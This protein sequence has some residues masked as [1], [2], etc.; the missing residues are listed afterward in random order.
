MQKTWLSVALDKEQI[1]WIKARAC[2]P[3]KRGPGVSSALRAALDEA[4]RRDE[5]AERL[6]KLCQ[7]T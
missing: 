3:D 5:L 4:K 1:E 7:T 6:V 2:T